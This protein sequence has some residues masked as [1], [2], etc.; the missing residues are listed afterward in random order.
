MNVPGIWRIV[1]TSRIELPVSGKLFRQPPRAFDKMQPDY[2][3]KY[4]G[5]TLASDVILEGSTL[6][7]VGPPLLNLSEALQDL[8]VRCGGPEIPVPEGQWADGNRISRLHLDLGAPADEV[9]FSFANQSYSVKPSASWA[10]VFEGR[11]VA[12]TVNKDNH[13]QTLADWAQNYT[14]NHGVTAVI[15]YDN[16]SESYS[17]EELLEHMKTVPGLEI[18]VVVD[19]PDKF[20][21]LAG[22]GDWD[23][24]FG[25]YIAWDHARWRFAR[26]AAFVFQGDAD[27][28]PMTSDG[29]SLEEH[30]AETETGTL[31]YPVCNAPAVLREGLDPDRPVRRHS[32]YWCLD[33][34]K[35]LWSK[36]V[37][38]QPTRLKDE[39]QPA[40]H[41]VIGIYNRYSEDVVARHVLGVHR[42]W[43]RGEAAAYDVKEREFNPET[44][45]FDP[46]SEAVYRKTFPD[47]FEDISSSENETGEKDQSTA[48]G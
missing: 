5:L 21:N 18:C 47:L 37:A 15:I 44:D 46:Q 31:L 33:L 32:D 8:V 2:M 30:V 41:A 39:F 11:S 19:W 29:R 13:L 25:Q 9:T 16:Q 14:V 6:H 43:R 12:V 27:E 48:E 28:F 35:G 23:S 36:K 34:T 40:N 20:G 7:V 3:M 22:P 42:D 24:D 10:D 26:K 38:Y 1:K 45:K 17:C 4:D